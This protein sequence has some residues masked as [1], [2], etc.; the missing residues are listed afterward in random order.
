MS[1]IIPY[2]N[3][4]AY[5]SRAV[6]SVQAQTY[7]QFELLLV[8][9]ASTDAGP[10]LAKQLA[11]ADARIRLLS[12]PQA[13]VSY[14]ANT[15][16]QACTSEFVARLDADDEMPPERLAL[17]KQF[18][19]QNPQCM[20]VTGQVLYRRGDMATQGFQRY[21]DW[22]N[23]L[24]SSEQIALNRFIELPCANPSMMWRRQV[25]NSLG[26]FAHG[27]WPEDY[28]FWLR[29]LD[30]GF[31]IGKV[32]KPVLYWYDYHQRL[33]RTHKR[34]R[35]QAFFDAKMHY[36]IRW[37]RRH[38][39]NRALAI[40]GGRQAKRL[41]APLR[42]AGLNPQYFIDLRF[43]QPQGLQFVPPE[44]MPPPGQWFVL[45]MVGRWGARET[46]RAHLDE[47]AYRPGH[48]YLFLA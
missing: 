32:P 15:A 20:A 12:E 45:A 27:A 47:W 19:E 6:A 10:Q 38:L 41:L 21:V 30:A 5:L 4:S 29:L 26:Y 22:L 9:N 18:L 25:H 34:Y 2:R 35:E 23:A 13:G 3:A 44:K 42:Q 24:T 33:T 36:L 17:Q 16:L 39:Q 1:V 37:L 48:D 31:C 40:W 14:A 28:E 46:I 7:K 11:A 43:R 8:D